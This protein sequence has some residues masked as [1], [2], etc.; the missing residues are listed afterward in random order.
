MLTVK[1]KRGIR[2]VT[3]LPMRY[4]DDFDRRWQAAVK[5]IRGSGADL[6]KIDLAIEW[7][8]ANVR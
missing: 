6:G 1:Q 2:A 4:Q 8:E 7:S 5:R 3:G